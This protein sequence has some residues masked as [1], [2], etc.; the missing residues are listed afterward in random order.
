MKIFFFLVFFFLSATLYAQERQYSS[1]NDQAIKYFALASQNLDDHLYDEAIADLQK[2][3]EEDSKF[4]EAHVL[5]ADVYR[6]K[7]HY[8]EAIDQYRLALNINPEFNRSIYYRLGD[9]ELHQGEYA[10]AKQHLQRYLDLNPKAPERDQIGKE[11]SRIDQL[12]SAK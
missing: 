10:E 1:T 7:W 2:A 9:C 4:I 12:E 3:I 6:Q 5:L 8:K 11:L